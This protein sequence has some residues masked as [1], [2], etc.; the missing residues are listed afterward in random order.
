[1]LEDLWQSYTLHNTAHWTA[2]NNSVEPWLG[3][4]FSPDMFLRYLG[5]PWG[6]QVAGTYQ[7]VGHRGWEEDPTNPLSQIDLWKLETHNLF[8]GLLL[9]IH[10]GDL[11]WALL[12][13]SKKLRP[14]G[15]WSPHPLDIYLDQLPWPFDW[16]WHLRLGMCKQVLHGYRPSGWGSTRPGCGS[17]GSFG[18]L[19]VIPSLWHIHLGSYQRACGH[20]I[21]E[22]WASHN[23]SVAPSDHLRKLLKSIG[24]CGESP[25][26]S[27]VH[28]IEPHHLLCW[29]LGWA[30]YSWLLWWTWVPCRMCW[31]SWAKSF[32]WRLLLV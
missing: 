11:S 6:F 14:P 29:A 1:M 9:C 24:N 27:W 17:L 2:G 15:G 32:P 13:Q 5:S 20:G 19:L 31:S 28:E 25:R 7:A 30:C 4:G 16:V 12:I 18:A 3:P 26:S 8:L 21:G 23:S 22:P 10:F